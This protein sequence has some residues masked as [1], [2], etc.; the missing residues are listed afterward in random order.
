ML[1][2]LCVAPG[3]FCQSR[4]LLCCL[5]GI[6]SRVFLSC[7]V[8]VFVCLGF[9]L[10]NSSLPADLG[11]WLNSVLSRNSLE[12]LGQICCKQREVAPHLPSF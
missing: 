6:Y 1:S 5:R 11:T 4:A 2:C 8:C 9:V 10:P 12:V 3:P 7:V